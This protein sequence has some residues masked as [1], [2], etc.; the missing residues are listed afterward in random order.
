MKYAHVTCYTVVN[1]RKNLPLKSDLV[2][3]LFLSK[4]FLPLNNFDL[5]GYYFIRRDIV[6]SHIFKS[7]KKIVSYGQNLKFS[8]KKI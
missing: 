2:A 6:K 8:K 5:F 7:G 4:L 3:A 1:Y